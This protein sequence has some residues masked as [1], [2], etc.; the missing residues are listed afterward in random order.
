MIKQSII[1]LF[2]MPRSGTTWIGKI[3]DSHTRT[4]YRHEPDT[5]NKIKKIPLLE[6]AEYSGK[7][8]DFVNSYV[9]QFVLSRRL[10]INGKLPFFNKAYVSQ[11]R[12]AVFRGS[13]LLSG[14]LSKLKKD[15]RLPVIRPVNA[16]H[17]TDF[18]VVWKS[19]QLLGRMGIIVNNLPNCKGVHILRHPCG[20]I[21]SILGGE[22]DKK[23]TSFVSASEDYPLYELLLDTN[24]A[25]NYGLTLDGLKALTPEERLAWRWVLFNE[26]A[27]DDTKN[28]K[29]VMVL[30][31]EDM[32]ANPV[33]TTQS[34]FSFCELELCEQ[35]MGFLGA[36]TSK[37]SRS[38][39]S[40]Y[41]NPEKAANKWRTVLPQEKI[42]LIKSI[43][44]KSSIG[45]YY[46][47]DF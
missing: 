34:C 6:N 11:F 21:A 40:V 42:E 1:L 27:R 35:T 38:Y 25:T 10:E 43:V 7:Y 22:S 17:L 5:W 46:L 37:D 2:G 39:Y 18:F 28:N 12:Q 41:K 9:E 29:N 3:F 8:T 33:K 20:Y 45:Q 13:V 26:K 16:H 44:E 23:F 4:L 47:D 36:S 14:A 30:R 32:C 19:I 31:Y 24:Q 15:L